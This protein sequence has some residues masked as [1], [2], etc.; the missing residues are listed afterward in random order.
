MTSQCRVW[1]SIRFTRWSGMLVARQN[2]RAGSAEFR[3][4]RV[5]DLLS[6]QLFPHQSFLEQR[7]R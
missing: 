3:D 4:D 1:L 5:K 2:S 7:V 6:L